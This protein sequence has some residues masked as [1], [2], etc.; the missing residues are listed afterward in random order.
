MNADGSAQRNLTRNRAPD[1]WLA[2][3]RGQAR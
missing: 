3:S 1:V 2:W